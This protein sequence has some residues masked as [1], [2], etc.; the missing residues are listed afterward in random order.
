MLK[1]ILSKI[2]NKKNQGQMVSFFDLSPAEKETIMKKAAKLSTQDQQDLLKEY[3]RKFG[4]LQTNT[5]K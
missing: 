1:N 4:K 3:D 5:C 2:S